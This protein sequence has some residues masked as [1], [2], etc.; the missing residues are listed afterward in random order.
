MASRVTIGLVALIA[1]AG[2]GY[3]APR[4]LI[5]TGVPP[6]ARDPQAA[7]VA[8]AALDA[9]RMLNDNPIGRLMFPSARVTRVWRDPAHCAPG[10][11]GG[12]EPTA[13]YRAEVEA[14]G[15]FG[16][17]GRSFTVTCGGWAS[18]VVR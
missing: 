18:S 16:I 5:P 17:P 15:W 9:V 4:W 13:D 2:A 14:L 7:T 3:A 1:I 10:E 8:H 12:R 11:P 6:Y